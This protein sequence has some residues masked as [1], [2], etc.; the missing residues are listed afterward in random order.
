MFP[1]ACSR[2]RVLACELLLC[3]RKALERLHHLL[4]RAQQQRHLICARRIDAHAD[5]AGGHGLRD[6]DRLIDRAHDGRDQ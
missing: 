1:A 6:S 3:G 4:H 2:A 5:V